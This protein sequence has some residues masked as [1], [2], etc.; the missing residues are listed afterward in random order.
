MDG[1][2]N[3]TLAKEEERAK[4]IYGICE[5]CGIGLVQWFLQ[6]RYNVLVTYKVCTA[7]LQRLI[8]LNLTPEQYKHL[9]S[10]GHKDNEFLL[11]SDFYDG[12]G[13]ALQPSI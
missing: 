2:T 3:Q 6:D 4:R 12:E 9:L 7:C 11:H 13:N 8:T 5:A 1:E 10:E